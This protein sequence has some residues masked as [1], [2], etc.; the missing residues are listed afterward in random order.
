[1]KL[2]SN[3][4]DAFLKIGKQ[5][6]EIEGVRLPTA[7]WVTL[8]T[9]IIR[10]EIVMNLIKV[11]LN[12]NEGATP[13]SVRWRSIRALS[14]Y[15]D[16]AGII[17]DSISLNLNDFCP[18]IRAISVNTIGGIGMSAEQ[19]RVGEILIGEI[20]KGERGLASNQVLFWIKELKIRGA[21]P[22]LL[23]SLDNEK[24]CSRV[25]AVEILGEMKVEDA[26]Q[27]LIHI[28]KTGESSERYKAAEALGNIGSKEAVQPL[29]EVLMEGGSLAEKAAEALGKIGDKRA[30][31]PITEVFQNME[32][33]NIRASE[34]LP[35][36]LMVLDVRDAIPLIEE[37]YNELLKTYP[38]SRVWA[39]VSENLQ[40]FKKGEKIEY[41]VEKR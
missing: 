25:Y 31:E 8:L 39:G 37:K 30:I 34:E 14:T 23:E 35:M 27:K 19:G 5:T 36:A 38:N 29:I 1:M 20:R 28:L 12:E 13:D 24:Y 3:T 18:H 9:P 6:K 32:K 10:E 33:Y 15:S 16:F 2:R 22:L 21:I 4:A 40:R 17:V 7:Q 41:P 26:V 11:A